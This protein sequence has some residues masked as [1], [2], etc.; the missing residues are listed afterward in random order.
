[1]QLE[2][3]IGRGTA[4][5]V[6]QRRKML[7]GIPAES[8]SAKPPSALGTT[9]RVMLAV[10]SGGEVGHVGSPEQA[11]L[12]SWA[13]AWSGRE[14]PCVRGAEPA[15]GQELP[16]S[17]GSVPPCLMST[18]PGSSRNWTRR[19]TWPGRPGTWGRLAMSS[20]AGGGWWLFASTVAGGGRRP[21]RGCC[22]VLSLSE[23]VNRWTWKTRSA[24]TPREP[25]RRA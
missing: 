2:C 16:G 4:V 24:T 11:L 7:G 6:I 13:E 1:M 18:G 22:A 19:W 14:E 21:R 17:S 25:S 20:R 23:G 15:I 5:P 3:S 9:G 8:P 10:P 12:H